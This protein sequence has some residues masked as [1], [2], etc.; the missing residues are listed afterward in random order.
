MQSAPDIGMRARRPRI[1][2]FDMIETVF[3]LDA[4]RP[5]LAALGLPALALEVLYTATLRDAFALACAGSYAPFKSILEGALD[6]LLARQEKSASGLQKQ[7]VLDGMA[8]L[9]PHDD[10]GQAFRT[11][12]EAGLRVIALSNGAAA[13]TRHLLERAGLDAFVEEVLSTDDVGLSKPRPEVY[14]HAARAME[15]EPGEMALVATHPWDVNGAQAAGLIGGFVTRG[16]PY[17]SC[18]APPSVAGDTL[19][20]VA[21]QLAAL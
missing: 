11:L 3:S 15:A 13:T 2:A 7:A 4:L 1:V 14:R 8:A 12:R 21:G 10:A 16:R 17:P 20:D 19:F 18:F 5:G 9:Q 6:E